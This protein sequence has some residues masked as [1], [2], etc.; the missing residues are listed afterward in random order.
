MP[1]RDLESL[2]TEMW[3]KGLRLLEEGNV[4]LDF[5]PILIPNSK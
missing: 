4:K 3:G 1:E 2:K 5:L